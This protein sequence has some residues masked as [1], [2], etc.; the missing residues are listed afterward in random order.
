MSVI[1]VVKE[2]S[3]LP[4]NAACLYTILYFQI[5]DL[6]RNRTNWALGSVPSYMGTANGGEMESDELPASG[7]HEALVTI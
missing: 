5:C 6:P 4:C 3:R 1:V 7:K 2:S